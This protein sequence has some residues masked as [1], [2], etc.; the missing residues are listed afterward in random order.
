M[1]GIYFNFQLDTLHIDIGF[2]RVLFR[3]FDCLS[4]YEVQNIRHF[5]FSG[6]CGY[7]TDEMER[8][9]HRLSFWSKVER[10]LEEFPNVKG[11]RVVINIY[12][13]LYFTNPDVG[14]GH[15]YVEIFDEYVPRIDHQIEFYH[16]FPEELRAELALKGYIENDRSGLVV[17]EVYEV[18]GR[19]DG[20]ATVVYGWHRALPAEYI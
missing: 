13:H 3:F 2:T 1:A 7:T 8:E 17:N 20:V 9:Q 18:Y 15:P 12:L 4:Q 11:F 10:T 6:A 5:A 14:E 19:L 16:A